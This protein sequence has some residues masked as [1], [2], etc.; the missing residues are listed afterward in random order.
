[1]QAHSKKKLKDPKP[2]NTCIQAHTNMICWL[3]QQKHRVVHKNTCIMGFIPQN[4]KKK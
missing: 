3:V 1:M 2:K 4:D